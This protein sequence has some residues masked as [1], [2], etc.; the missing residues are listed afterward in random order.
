L[1]QAGTE[2]AKESAKVKKPTAKLGG[3]QRRISMTDQAERVSDLAKVLDRHQ[4][5]IASAW[6]KKVQQ[7]PDAHYRELPGKE[8]RTSTARGLRAIRE[9]LVTNSYTRLESYL[10]DVCLTRLQ[11]GF[12]I[13]EVIRALL[14]CKDAALPVIWQEYADGSANGTTDGSNLVGGSP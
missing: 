6:A 4:D 12:S 2:N 7:L 11:M 14:A 13:G 5:K 10:T 8:I 9:A 1:A 3:I